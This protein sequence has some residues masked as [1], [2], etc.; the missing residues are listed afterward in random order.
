MPSVVDLVQ[1]TL[2]G[3]SEKGVDGIAEE[4]LKDFKKR[5][6]ITNV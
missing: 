3:L 6:L 2:K 5:K 4:Q 1:Q